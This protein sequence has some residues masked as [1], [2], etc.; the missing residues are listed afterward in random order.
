MADDINSLLLFPEAFCVLV[1]SKTYTIAKSALVPAAVD[2]DDELVEANS[3]LQLLGVAAGIGAAIPGAAVLQLA[4]GAWVLRLAALVF[5]AGTVTA[6]RIRPAEARTPA[7]NAEERAELR[8]AGIIL[9]ASA[10]GLLRATVG[11]MTFLIAFGFRK[12]HAPSWWFG[13]VLAASMA[14]TL[15]GAAIAPRLRQT[16]REERII[17]GALIGLALVGLV[18]GI[19]GGDRRLW[20]A[21]LAAAVAVAASVSKLAFDSLVQRDAPDAARGRSFARFETRFQLLWVAGAFMPV[22]LPMPLGL[23]FLIVA[24]TAA[25]ACVSYVG[26]LRATHAAPP[27]R[28]RSDVGR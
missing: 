28:K 18:C 19:R 5:A 21:V 25:F 2:S 24:G 11:F 26:G 7:P 10:M 17:T 27:R 6:L 13:I 15:V 12:A 9:A 20:A 14:G 1:A 23:G 22:V 3:K 4:S 16:V 8:A